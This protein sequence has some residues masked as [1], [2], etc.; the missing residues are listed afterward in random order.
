M[1]MIVP[2]AMLILTLPVM[3]LVLSESIKDDT[4]SRS[5]TFA[6]LALFDIAEIA[7]ETFNRGGTKKI[8]PLH[9]L[10]KSQ[11]DKPT[12]LNSWALA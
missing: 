12:F 3:N 4:F 10:S 7:V 5:S 11:K 1:K 6:P 9:R 2:K 8:E